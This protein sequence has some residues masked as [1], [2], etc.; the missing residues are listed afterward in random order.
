MA[1]RFSFT[2]RDASAYL[3][4]KQ[5]LITILD[6]FYFCIIDV[7]SLLTLFQIIFLARKIFRYKK[8]LQGF[9]ISLTE[10]ASVI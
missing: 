7:W 5:K 8:K 1:G 10:A 3:T 6:V 4:E 2:F 9:K